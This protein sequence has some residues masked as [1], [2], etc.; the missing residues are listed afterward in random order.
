MPILNSS[1]PVPSE[2]DVTVRIAL[3]GYRTRPVFTCWHKSIPDHPDR[4]G[5]QRL[6]SAQFDSRLVAPAPNTS[7]LD[8]PYRPGGQQDLTRLRRTQLN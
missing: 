2:H 5:G 7:R 1:S 8:S 6:S 4:P 3:E